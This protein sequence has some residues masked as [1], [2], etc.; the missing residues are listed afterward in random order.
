MFLAVA[1][2]KLGVS[3]TATPTKITSA[4]GTI[5]ARISLPKTLE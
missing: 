1:D 5:A 4:N 2:S 3:P